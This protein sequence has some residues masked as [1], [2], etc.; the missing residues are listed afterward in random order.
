MIALSFFYLGFFAKVYIL[1]D[2]LTYVYTV[3]VSIGPLIL[4]YGWE[5]YRDCAKDRRNWSKK[6]KYITDQMAKYNLVKELG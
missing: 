5:L 4:M 3:P 6:E 1:P 2:L